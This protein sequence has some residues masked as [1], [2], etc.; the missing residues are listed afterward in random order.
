MSQGQTA[1]KSNPMD[2]SD[3]PN[4]NSGGVGTRTNGALS[5][6]LGVVIFLALFGTAGYLTY[7]TLTTA[8]EP[9]A[10]PVPNMFICSETGKAFEYAMKMGEKWPVTSPYSQKKTGYPA[11]RCYW[12]RDGKQRRTPVY[13]LIKEKMDQPGDTMCPDCG[14]LVIGHNPMPPP[15]V[16]YEDA[17]SQPAATATP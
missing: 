7:Q 17:T 5:G 9:E 8:P 2:D 14:R 15:G 13:V 16:P 3:N 4:T 11:E 1:N 6:P 10:T 12:T